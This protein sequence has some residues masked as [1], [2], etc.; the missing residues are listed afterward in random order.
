MN[1]HPVTLRL[2]A[3]LAVV[4]VAACGTSSEDLSGEGDTPAP[5]ATPAAGNVPGS[6]PTDGDGGVPPGTPPPG[7][8][9]AITCAR[10]TAF[11]AVFTIAEASGAVEVSIGGVPHL[12]VNA[13]SKNKG[14]AILIPIPGGASPQ[15]IVL[16]FDPATSDDIEGLAAAG[17]AVYGL[18]SAGAVMRFLPSAGGFTRDGAAYRIGPQ[19]LSCSKL[20]DTNCGKNWEGLC[21][22]RPPAAGAATPKCLGY[23]ASKTESAL[24]CVVMQ[25]TTLSIDPT[26]API[27]LALPKDSVS[28]CA[29]GAS[30]LVVTTNDGNG[31]KSYVVDEK[32]G[33]LAPLPVT[34]HGSNEAVQVGADGAFYQFEDSSSKTSAASRFT[35]QGL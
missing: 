2:L 1:T 24:Y 15:S 28:D 12:L 6:T 30:A 27:T 20:T 5:G 25:G 29:F 31:S 26:A 7:T 23:A 3:L 11:P 33:A 17:G 18:T 14:A 16:P 35:C 21:L 19:P 8:P 10:D 34:G 13:D 22:R 4:T 9:G 32:T